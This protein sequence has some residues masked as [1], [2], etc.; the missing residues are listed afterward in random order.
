MRQFRRELLWRSRESHEP[1]TMDAASMR[2]FAITR[3]SLVRAIVAG[4]AAAALAACAVIPK[5]PRQPAPVP[6]PTPV[7]SSTLPADQQRHRV[8]VL[9]PMSGRAAAA[10]QSIANA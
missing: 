6:F 10:G 8:A 5:G 9:V 4:T 7:L 2:A 3:R 1:G